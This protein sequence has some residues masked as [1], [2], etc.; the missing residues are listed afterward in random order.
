MR[1]MSRNNG[2][3]ESTRRTFAAHGLAFADARQPRDAA[4]RNQSPPS[5]ERD[6]APRADSHIACIARFR[7]SLYSGPYSHGA[8]IA[9][10]LTGIGLTDS[11]HEIHKLEDGFQKRVGAPRP[12]SDASSR[13][14]NPIPGR[15]SS[16]L[17]CPDD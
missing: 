3:Q 11:P 6:R 1:A 17:F 15:E 13:Q 8:R 9:Y 14:L 4:G 16:C 12:S 7:N 2:S 10:E 5:R